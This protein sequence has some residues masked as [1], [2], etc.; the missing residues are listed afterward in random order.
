MSFIK[1][2]NNISYGFGV[3]GSC[4]M[5]GTIH[6]IQFIILQEKQMLLSTELVAP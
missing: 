1:S 6:T 2:S 3:T 4:D 5:E